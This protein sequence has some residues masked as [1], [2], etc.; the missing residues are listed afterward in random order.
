MKVLLS[1]RPEYANKILDGSKRFEYRRRVHKD[2]T[3]KTI[4]IYAT[5]PVGKV[6][7][8]F[9]IKSI[10]TNR[11]ARL[12]TETKGFSGITKRFFLQYFSGRGVAHAIE[13]A[14]VTK[15]SHPKELAEFLPSGLAPQSYAYVP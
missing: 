13:V 5:K 9:T 7:G 1:I 10:H 12:W 14:S 11:P 3:V 8:E 4:I 2:H 6:I 15:Y